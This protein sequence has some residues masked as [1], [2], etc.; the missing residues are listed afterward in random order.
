M[1]TGT[2]TG[3]LADH[4]SIVVLEVVLS[5]G[6]IIEVKADRR[7]A[8][9]VNE[10]IAAEGDAQIAFEPWQVGRVLGAAPTGG[11]T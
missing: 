5:D 4:G 2:A 11:S 9:T 7:M 3:V 10:V 8:A 1:K 6:A